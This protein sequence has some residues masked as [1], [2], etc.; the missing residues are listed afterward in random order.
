VPNLVPQAEGNV[1]SRGRVIYGV[2]CSHRMYGKS[3]YTD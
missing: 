1:K 3:H 2:F